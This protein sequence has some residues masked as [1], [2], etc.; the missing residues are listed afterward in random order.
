MNNKIFKRINYNSKAA[1]FILS[2]FI[3][4]IFIANADAQARRIRVERVNPAP[5]RVVHGPHNYTT[6]VVGSRKYFYDGGS[7]YTRTRAGYNVIPAPIGARIRILPVGCINMRIGAMDY[8]YYNGVYYNFLPDQNEYVVVEKPAGADN[9]QD[10]KLD[11]VKMYDGSTL[12][13]VFQG[14]TDSTISLKIG[15]QV[16]DINISDIISIEFAPSIDD[17]ASPK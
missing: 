12:L 1:I 10:L 16:R 15:D 2:L 14:A 4:F 8:Y 5:V 13:G 17:K 9:V 3:S 7:F 11:Q 6:V